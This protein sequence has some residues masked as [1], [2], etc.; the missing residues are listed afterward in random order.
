VFKTDACV[1]HISFSHFWFKKHVL[2]AGPAL[3]SGKKEYGTY[4]AGFHTST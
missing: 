4:F 1:G 3:S 2:E